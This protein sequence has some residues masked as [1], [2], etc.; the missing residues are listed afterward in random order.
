MPFVVF[1]GL[2][3][4]GKST[5]ARQ[6]APALGLPVLDKDDF[7]DALFEERGIGDVAW[8]ASLSRA[9]DRRRVSR[10]LVAAP[11]RTVGPI[12]YA[13]GLASLARG[14]DRGSPLRL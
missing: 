9:G 4:S 3:G 8:R 5:L 11:G 13:D 10:L 1:S 2:P 12:R 6:I 14:S 7:L